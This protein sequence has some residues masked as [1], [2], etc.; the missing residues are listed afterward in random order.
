MKKT[1]PI[2][3]TVVS[4]LFVL[5]ALIFQPT[6]GN[7]LGMVLNWA[8]ILASVALLVAIAVLM[9]THFRYILVGRKGFIYS[10]VL[11]AAFLLSFVGGLTQGVDNPGYL[12]W[13]ASIQTPLE[14]SLL[15]LVALIMTSAAVQVFRT[16]GW[17]ALTI[18]FGIS[19]IVFLIFSLGI[20]ELLNIPQLEPINLAIQ[21][22]S[23]IGA[24]GLLIG[25]ALGSLLVALRVLFGEERPYSG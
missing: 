25:V 7:Y 5:A 8:I 9:V 11:L 15:G 6:L 22:L 21:K 3:V 18:S 20:L 23:L 10:I 19:A 4:G 2:I 17:S 16:R 24:R 13:I 14:A 12:K 1:L